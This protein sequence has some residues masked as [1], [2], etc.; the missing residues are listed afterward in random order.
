MRRRLA[1]SA[2]VDAL[3]I[4]GGTYAALIV[5]AVLISAAYA[6]VR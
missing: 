6:A 1:D 4:L 3:L 2:Y 5:A